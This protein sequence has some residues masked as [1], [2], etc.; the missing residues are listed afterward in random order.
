MDYEAFIKE[1]SDRRHKLDVERGRVFT[2]SQIENVLDLVR[3]E[4][5]PNG[6][7]GDDECVL[8]S[9]VHDILDIPRP[10]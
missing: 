2:L 6:E 3:D 9:R 4:K 5:W 7:F 8:W 10:R 1:E